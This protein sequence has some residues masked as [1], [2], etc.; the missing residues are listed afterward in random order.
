MARRVGGEGSPKKTSLNLV[1]GFYHYLRGKW[2]SV[3]AQQRALQQ[4]KFLYVYSA[5]IVFCVFVVLHCSVESVHA[6]N[7]AG[8]FFLLFILVVESMS[9]K[10]DTD[11]KCTFLGRLCMFVFAFEF[12]GCWFW[13][14]QRVEQ[15][16][17]TDK[18]LPLCMDHIAGVWLLNVWLLCLV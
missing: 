8:C 3:S 11:L 5:C 12:G 14:L 4:R 17:P 15:A 18:Q 7:C 13:S 10:R 1:A 9:E 6:F 2:G 16:N